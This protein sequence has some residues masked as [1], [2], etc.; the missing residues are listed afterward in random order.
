MPFPLMTFIRTRLLLALIVVLSMALVTFAQP[1]E[2][3]GKY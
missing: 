2:A 1:V 3:I